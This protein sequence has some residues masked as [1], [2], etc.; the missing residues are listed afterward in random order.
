MI[1]NDNIIG[2][3][4]NN[5]IYYNNISYYYNNVKGSNKTSINVSGHVGNV[6]QYINTIHVYHE[7][8]ISL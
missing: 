4:K 8:I 7:S 1:K 5:I 2:I 3:A 6:T